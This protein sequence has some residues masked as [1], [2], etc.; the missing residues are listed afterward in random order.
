MLPVQV[1]GSVDQALAGGRTVLIGDAKRHADAWL[2]RQSE[3]PVFL[4]DFLRGGVPVGAAFSGVVFSRAE[5]PALRAVV[6]SWLPAL[7]AFRH[8]ELDDRGLREAGVPVP[9]PLRPERALRALVACQG[10]SMQGV[11]A[12]VGLSMS[13]MHVAVH[14]L[15]SQLG[16]GVIGEQVKRGVVYP[17]QVGGPARRFQELIC[18]EQ[19][20]VLSAAQARELLLLRAGLEARRNE[21]NPQ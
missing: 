10:L 16:P 2:S 1:A 8:L 13:S 11:G 3:A 14:E 19:A 18:A 17:A 6:W 20:R 9:L 5:V 21:K 12:S 15:R 4:H 7:T